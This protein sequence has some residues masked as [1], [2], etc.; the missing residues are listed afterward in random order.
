MNNKYVIFD[1]DGT[2]ADIEDRR[3]LSLKENGKLDWDKFF[4]PD[5]IHCDKPNHSVIKMAQILDESGHKIVIFSGRSK[6]T[7]LSTLQWLS[8][9]NVP[10]HILRMRP[11]NK[12]YI[13]DDQLKQDWLDEIFPGEHKENIVAVFDDRNKVVDMWRKNGLPCFQVAPG[14]F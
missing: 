9:H 3:K 10:F 12:L 5:N 8:K 14:D 1:L 7:R 11:T 4:D 6:G 13:A 2:L